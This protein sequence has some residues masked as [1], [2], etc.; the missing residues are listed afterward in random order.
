M[1]VLFISD[2]PAHNTGYGKITANFAN[3][4][5]NQGHT[6]LIMGG[7][8]PNAQIPF[9]AQEWNGCKLWLMPGYGNAE[10]V[11]WIL[12]NEKPDIV[13]AN[14][15]PRFFDYL[16]KLDNEIRKVCPLVFYHLWDDSPFPEFN[17]PYYECCDKI[18]TGSKFTYDLL[19]GNYR[20]P[21]D[22]VPIGFDPTIYYPLSNEEKLV[23]TKEFNTKT[24]S[25]FLDTNFIVGYVG[26]H[27][28]RKQ[29]LDIVNVFSIWSKDKP[30]ALLFLHTPTGDAGHSLEFAIQQH[31]RDTKIIINNA[32]P[33][34][35]SDKLMN[36]FYNFFSVLINRSSAEGFGMPIAEAMLS[37]T[38]SIAVKNAGPSGLI[39]EENG[40]L[41]EPIVTP[42][43][44]DAT[45]PY[46]HTR[47]VTD[48]AVIKALDEAYFNRDLLKEKASKCRQYII[49]NY[50][51][52][53]TCKDFEVALQNVIK[54]WVQYPEYT[55]HMFPKK[56][57]N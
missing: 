24:N 54:D 56:E 29:L 55:V 31:Y 39:T 49:D 1:K 34:I 52:D 53:K 33:H 57:G 19:K 15:D 48:D 41:L 13:V 36:Q 32:I 27:A 10:Q 21:I 44:S 45:T 28:P 7:V 35:H 26:R 12:E 5:K 4:L 40:W 6:V 14:A 42:F 22:Y 16:F 3:H 47:H 38:P 46:I 37:G 51:L 23:F 50:G 20:K 43:Y 25:A 8:N 11:R 9:Q 18:I 2:S 17:V 30:D